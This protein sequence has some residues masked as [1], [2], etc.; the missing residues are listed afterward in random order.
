MERVN[1]DVGNEI[2]LGM[3]IPMINSQISQVSRKQKE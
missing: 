2:E 3:K 1:G